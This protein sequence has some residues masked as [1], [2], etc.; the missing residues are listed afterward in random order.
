MLTSGSQDGKMASDA[1]LKVKLGGLHGG[2]AP[3]GYEDGA[4]PPPNQRLAVRGRLIHESVLLQVQKAQCLGEHVSLLALLIM[5]GQAFWL[6]QILLQAHCI[7]LQDPSQ[8]QH[9]GHWR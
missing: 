7:I 9:C 1:H 8:A 3:E 2:S 6:L 5:N 4:L